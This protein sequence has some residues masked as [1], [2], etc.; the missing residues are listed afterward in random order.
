MEIGM[1]ALRKHINNN[2][3]VD[4]LLNDALKKGP[5]RVRILSREELKMEINK[6]KNISLRLMDELK[7][8]KIKVPA[9]ASKSNIDQPEN[10]Y[11][12]IEEKKASAVDIFDDVD[13]KSEG[14][15][16]SQVSFN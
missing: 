16:Y 6:F 5:K 3:Q 11:R 14:P 15:A 2:E 7:V 4:R 1:E 13:Q 10:G 8:N 12:A 9:Y